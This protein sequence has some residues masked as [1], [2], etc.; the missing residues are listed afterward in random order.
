MDPPASDNGIDASWT[1][2]SLLT[3]TQASS[4]LLSNN[5]GEMGTGKVSAQ[6]LSPA[7]EHT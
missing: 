4:L 2:L 1:L 6:A 5:P 7:G 3:D